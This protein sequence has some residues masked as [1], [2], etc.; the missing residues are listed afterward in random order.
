MQAFVAGFFEPTHQ[1]SHL[2]N[3]IAKTA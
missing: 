1:L 2:H 3:L